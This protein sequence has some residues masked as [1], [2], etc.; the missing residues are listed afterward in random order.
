MDLG[1]SIELGQHHIVRRRWHTTIEQITA[2]SSRHQSAGTLRP[3]IVRSGVRDWID[4]VAAKT[5]SNAT[6]DNCEA[7]SLVPAQKAEEVSE[8]IV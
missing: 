5:L 1:S 6:S 4:T 3:W 7:M 8:P 2:L